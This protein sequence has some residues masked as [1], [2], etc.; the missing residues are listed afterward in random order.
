M[1]GC[2]YMDIFVQYVRIQDFNGTF[3]LA[4]AIYSMGEL[5]GLRDRKWFVVYFLSHVP[6]PNCPDNYRASTKALKP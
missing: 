3:L 5:A 2:V 4:V 1:P 6:L